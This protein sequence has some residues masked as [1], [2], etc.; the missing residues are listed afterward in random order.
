MKYHY[1]TPEQVQREIQEYIRQNKTT[2]N[3]KTLIFLF[4]NILILATVILILDKSGILYKTFHH[5]NIKSISY[6]IDGNVLRIRFDVDKPVILTSSNTKEDY[7]LHLQKVILQTNDQ[8]KLEFSPVIIKT[9]IDQE[10]PFLDIQLPQSISANII[11]SVYL[12][13]NNKPIEAKKY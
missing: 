7:I 9:I 3:K 11:Q 13:L 1:K 6:R 10:N 5:K 12:V 2:P 8:N 4:M